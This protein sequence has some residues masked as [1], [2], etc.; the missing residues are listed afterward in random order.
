MKKYQKIHIWEFPLTRTFIEL[1]SEFRTK[2]FRTVVTQ[3]GSERK[4]L[5]YLNVKS[6][7][8]AIRRNHSRRNL[9]SW[10][11]GTKFDRGTAKKI[12]VP[13]WVLIECAK[14]ISKDKALGNP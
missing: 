1:P 4:F 3:T 11:R 8:Y 14:M 9:Y 7:R 6:E 10:I 5:D 13:L 12:G 2:M